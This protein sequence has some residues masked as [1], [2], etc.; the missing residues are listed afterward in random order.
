MGYKYIMTY[1]FIK[2]DSLQDFNSFNTIVG[3]RIKTEQGRLMDTYTAVELT[4][5]GTGI[6][7]IVDNNFLDSI[8]GLPAIID[9]YQPL[10]IL[11]K[12]EAIADG[13]MPDGE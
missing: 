6:F 7:A 1:G 12:V 11:T 8:N 13:M 3:N 2:F 10:T 5:T 9:S 4:K